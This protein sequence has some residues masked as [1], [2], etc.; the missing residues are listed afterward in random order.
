LLETI[1]STV[2]EFYKKE[3]SN[4]SSNDSNDS[5]KR[6]RDTSRDSNANVEDD[7]FTRSTGRTKK[8]VAKEPNKIADI[9]NYIEPGYY[10]HGVDDDQDL[11]DYDFEMNGSDMKANENGGRVLPPWSAPGNGM[12]S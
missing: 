11:Y 12:R 1:E 4:S 10:N 2:N 6:R 8:K 5:I 7:D 9:T 3:K